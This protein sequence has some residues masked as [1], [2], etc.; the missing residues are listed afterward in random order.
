[1]NKPALFSF[2]YGLATLVVMVL[3]TNVA[4]SA[5]STNLNDAARYA[6]VTDAM[7]AQLAVIDTKTEKPL[8]NIALKT[9][10]ESIGISKEGG[11]LAYA[12]RG[13]KAF[14]QLDLTTQRQKRIEVSQPISDLIVHSSGRWL[15]Y[16][17][18]QNTVVI[19]EMKTGKEKVLATAGKVSL[20]YHPADDSLLIAALDKGR[21]RRIQLTDDSQKT[22]LD[23]G[24]PMSPIS[25]MP[26]S[27]ALFFIAGGVLQRYSLLDDQLQPLTISAANFRPYIT[28]DSRSVLLLSRSKPSE[29]LSVNAYTYR[30]QSRYSLKNWQLPATSSH[31]F[32]VTGWLDQVAVLA[33]NQS[34]YSLALTQ[35]DGLTV[36]D[37]EDHSGAVRDMLVKADSKTLLFTREGSKKLSIF[38]MKS[39]QLSV[40]IPLDLHQP[41]HVLMGETNTL[42]H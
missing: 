5:D 19:V 33:D 18:T 29:L 36:Q 39:Q 23:I 10:A 37:T 26:N 11:Y 28:S 4:I 38:D 2:V 27:M 42:C 7:H 34:L 24:K 40:D 30:I 20:L 15:A 14:Y 9:V 25:M 17:S 16:V 21:L 12:K 8:P 3:F 31:D 1:M 13:E 41:N 32:I 6:F 22:L 35:T